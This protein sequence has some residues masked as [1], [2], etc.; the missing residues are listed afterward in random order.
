MSEQ[1]LTI[2]ALRERW[3]FQSPLENIDPNS[4]PAWYAWLAAVRANA[5]E[6]YS[7]R[8]EQFDTWL[9]GLLAEVWDEGYKGGW[10]D[11]ESIASVTPN[12]WIDSDKS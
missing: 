6:G 8:A 7:Q 12:P 2:A 1:E 9:H 4:E 5:H 11:C 3:A 10:A